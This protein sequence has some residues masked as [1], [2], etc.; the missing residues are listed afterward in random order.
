MQWAE[1]TKEAIFNTF[2]KMF[3]TIVEFQGDEG[4]ADYK[5]APKV[6]SYIKATDGSST[7]LLVLILDESFAFQMTADF[8]GTIVD[9]V[10]R[11]EMEDCMRE[12][13]NMV[14]GNWIAL[15]NKAFQLDLPRCALPPEDLQARMED[16][17]PLYI[18]GKKVGELSLVTM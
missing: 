16:A 3:Y 2:E 5:V 1:L 12:I 18:L 15:S 4:E 14:G 6:S 17:I 8:I 9:E 10:T 13:A 7:I 11:E